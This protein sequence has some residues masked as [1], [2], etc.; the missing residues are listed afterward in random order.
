MDERYYR[1]GGYLKLVELFSDPN[2]TNAHIG[3]CFSPTNRPLSRSV[4]KR[5]RERWELEQRHPELKN[6]GVLEEVTE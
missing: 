1:Y 6:G 3:R 5:W 2:N 4:A